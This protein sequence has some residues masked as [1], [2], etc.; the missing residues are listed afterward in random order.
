MVDDRDATDETVRQDPTL[1]GVGGADD[2]GVAETVA[3]TPPANPPTPGLTTMQELL[4]RIKK[5]DVVD[6][7][8]AR[9]RLLRA[10][11]D[12]CLAIEFAH[13]AGIIH[14]D[15]KPANIMLGDFGEVYVLDWGVARA[16]ADVA[17]VDS[18]A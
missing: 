18:A 7:A 9:R 17:D 10:F 5:G 12:V 1:K 2:V 13:S 14:R 16:V 15:L 6:E 8:T 3:H 4:E 11:A